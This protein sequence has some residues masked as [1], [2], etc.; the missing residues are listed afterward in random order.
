MTS[1]LK[2]LFEGKKLNI[3]LLNS[4]ELY[5]RYGPRSS[6]KVDYFHNFIKTELESFLNKDIYNVKLEQNI[7]SINSNKKKKCD[8]IIYKN[9]NPYIILAVKLIMTSYLKNKNNYWENLTGELSH[10]K[11]ANPNLQLIPINI[12]MN[13]VPHINNNIIKYFEYPTYNDL[14]IYKFL[15]EKEI[16]Y[17]TIN[18]IIDVLHQNIINEPFNKCP[19]IIGFNKKTP[20]R[21]LKNI[22]NPLI[23]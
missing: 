17:D 15:E 11:W 7:N 19:I 3:C 21:S 5:F 10:L 8:I 23:N 16:T 14:V 2:I 18:Y 13:K 4:F 20:F 1:K 6:K 9:N 22:L 12:I